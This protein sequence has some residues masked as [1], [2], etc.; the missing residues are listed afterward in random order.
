MGLIPL[1]EPIINTLI[2][3]GYPGTDVFIICYSIFHPESFQHVYD[4]VYIYIFLLLILFHLYINYFLKW[5]KEIE[6]HAP[7]IPIL[8]V[9]TKS[10]LRNVKSAIEQLKKNGQE[11]ITKEQGEHMAAE[12]NAYRYFECSAKTQEG[13]SLVFEECVR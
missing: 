13:L 3:I 8:L 11:P 10:D 5:Y 2:N 9:G 4:K 1:H 7:G 12:I 6:Q